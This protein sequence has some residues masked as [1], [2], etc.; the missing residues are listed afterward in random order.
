MRVYAVTNLTTPKIIG[1]AGSVVS[2]ARVTLYGTDGTTVLGVAKAASDGSWSIVAPALPEGVHDLTATATVDGRVVNPP[3]ALSLTIDTTAPDA[4]SMVDGA[5]AGDAEAGSWVRI[6]AINPDGTR[7]RLLATTAANGAENAGG[8]SAWS[9]TSKTPLPFGTQIRIIATD[10]AGNESEPTD[11][12]VAFEDNAAALSMTL[13]ANG[14]ARLYGENYRTGFSPASRRD[15]PTGIFVEKDDV[16]KIYISEGK[17]VSAIIG[18]EPAYKNSATSD[19]VTIKLVPGLNVIHAPEDGLLYLNNDSMDKEAH[20]TISVPSDTERAIV[21]NLGTDTY[22]DWVEMLAANPDARAVELRSEHALITVTY[23]QAKLHIKDPVE[24]LRVIDRIIE[25]EN[26]L[27]GISDNGSGVTDGSGVIHQFLEYAGDGWMYATN[28]YTA[29]VANS[30]EALLNHPKLT[31]DGWGPWHELGHQ[32]QQSAWTPSGAGEVTVNIYSTY[33]QYM[34]GNKSTVGKTASDVY[35]DFDGTEKNWDNIGNFDKLELY[36]QLHWAF[37]TDFY[38]LLHHEYRLLPPSQAPATDA[39]EKALFI[40][41]AS[42]ISGHNLI[43]FFEDWR[44]MEIDDGLRQD[45]QALGLKSMPFDLSE[46]RYVDGDH[47]FKTIG[48]LADL[49]GTYAPPQAIAH[50]GFIVRQG[51]AVNVQKLVSFDES[52]IKSATVLKN[53]VD[54][55]QLGSNTF[56]VII[57]DVQGDKNIIPVR[58]VVVPHDYESTTPEGIIA[59]AQKYMSGTE[60]DI[61]TLSLHMKLLEAILD[62]DHDFAGMAV[63]R[64]VQTRYEEVI[65]NIDNGLASLGTRDMA[66]SDGRVSISIDRDVFDD[67]VGAGSIHVK[68]YINDEYQGEILVPQ[69]GERIYQYYAGRIDLDSNSA[70]FYIESDKFPDDIARFEI[71]RTIDG[72]SRTFDFTG[73]VEEIGSDTAFSLHA[74]EY[75]IDDLA[76]SDGVTEDMFDSALQIHTNVKHVDN[77]GVV[78]Y[79][80]AG[81]GST[82]DF[83]PIVLSGIGAQVES[84]IEDG[85]AFEAL[86]LDESDEMRLSGPQELSKGGDAQSL[87]VVALEYGCAPSESNNWVLNMDLDPMRP[88]IA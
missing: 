85:L 65:G 22:A 60:G 61:D 12:F 23:E 33:V 8:E 51:E 29:Y 2:G 88:V 43:P 70:V 50:H 20:V 87:D 79:N 31:R 81:A 15:S 59:R 9:A 11:T 32:H 53:D 78:F 73:S 56:R 39:E 49:E 25:L 45:I 72:E 27:A 42:K 38:R 16:L 19:P 21:F 86:H 69:G 24:T 28:G 3:L 6:F 76:S 46:F 62:D 55:L 37:G 14:E 34:L 84:V 26:S 58:G 36:N 10:A 63:F 44:F 75:A 4:P 41:M 18:S 17:D 47:D 7:G 82:L 71:T 40:F 52:L 66:V 67:A 80:D 74:D 83:E 5:L 30:I 77:N 48:N 1:P 64:A 13:E 57:E 35:G 54:E 68:M